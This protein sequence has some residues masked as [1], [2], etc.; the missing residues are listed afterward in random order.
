MIKSNIDIN[1]YEGEMIEKKKAYIYGAGTYALTE[2]YRISNHYDILGIVVSDPQCEPE[3]LMNT[4]VISLREIKNKNSFFIICSTY[5]DEIS[6]TLSNNGFNNYITIEELTK[7]GTILGEKMIL[8]SKFIEIKNRIIDNIVNLTS[9]EDSITLDNVIVSLTS[10]PKRFKNLYIVIESI[11]KQIWKPKKIILWI[12]TDDYKKLPN[13]VLKIQDELF[14][15]RQCEDLK[16]YKKLIPALAEFPNEIIVTADDDLYYWPSWLKELVE[17]YRESNNAVVAH[18]VHRITSEN[19]NKYQLWKHAYTGPE[20]QKIS[21]WNFP[22][23]VAGILYPSNCFHSDV[24]NPELFMGLC[25]TADDIW[26]YWMF[27]LKGYSAIGTG[28]KDSWVSID[29]YGTPNLYE[30]N[31]LKNGNNRQLK[32]MIERYGFI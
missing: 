6:N 4:P 9:I 17:I 22:T 13:K 19:V 3:K 32:N 25:P 16:S 2:F 30:E 10:Y 11:K 21:P 31:V 20:S 7:N 26:F 1:I 8:E 18:R 5:F 24:L 28:R 14:E 29:N 15:I 23:G 12:Y 27:R